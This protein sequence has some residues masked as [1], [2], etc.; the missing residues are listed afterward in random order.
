MIPITMAYL[1]RKAIMNAVRTPPPRTLA[2]SYKDVRVW[3][4]YVSAAKPTLG[5]DINPPLHMPVS[6][7]MSS[8]LHP[9]RANGVAW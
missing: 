1:M 4:D 2:Q 7:S 6:G 8:G 9:A 5:F 3:E